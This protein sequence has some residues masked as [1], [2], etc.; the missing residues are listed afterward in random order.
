MRVTTRPDENPMKKVG[1]ASEDKAGFGPV[2]WMSLKE[3][4]TAIEQLMI[5]YAWYVKQQEKK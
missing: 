2:E 4:E 1:V 3:L 5:A